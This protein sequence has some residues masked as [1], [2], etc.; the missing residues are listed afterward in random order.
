MALAI[1]QVTEEIVLLVR[2]AKR[3]TGSKYLVL[4]GGVALNC[5]ANGKILR[6]GIFDDLWIQ[7]AAGDAGGAVGAAYAIWHILDGNERQV[8]GG[9][10]ATGGS[11]PGPEFSDNEIHRM[12]QKYDAKARLYEDFQ[13][14]ASDVAS[15]LTD[16]NVVGWF[17]AGWNS[18]RALSGARHPRRSAS[19]DGAKAAQSQGQIPRV[20]RPFAPSVLREDVADWFDLD[21]DSPYMLLVADVVAGKQIPMS[22]GA[23]VAVRPRQAQCA[24]VG[25]SR[26]HPCRLFR[27]GA[28][29]SCRD[30]PSL[31]RADPPVQ[32]AH[33][34]SGVVNTSFNVRGEPIVCTPEDAFN[35]LMGRKSTFSPLAIVVVRKT[36]QEQP[37]WPKQAIGGRNSSSIDP[38]QGR[39][40]WNFATAARF[41]PYFELRRE[42]ACP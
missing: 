22:R 31:L 37:R 30:Q 17:R 15:K 4:A 11:Y 7:P 19:P 21:V 32:G 26:R 38:K 28:D 42:E 8:N 1:Q 41:V 13:G 5:V 12:L 16:G 39:E 27:A 34:L 14:L 18:A 23:E 24:E 36:K 20:F 3:L 33:G 10:D 2:T 25:D 9:R 6:A 29:G 40:P 35:C